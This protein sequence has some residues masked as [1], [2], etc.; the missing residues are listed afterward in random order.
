MSIAGGGRKCCTI[1]V[2]NLSCVSKSHSSQI[3]HC[4]NTHT[5]RT[6]TNILSSLSPLFTQTHHSRAFPQPSLLTILLIMR[7]IAYNRCTWFVLFCP[8]Y[9]DTRLKKRERKLVHVTMS[10]G[11]RPT[12]CL[13]LSIL[14]SVF[15]FFVKMLYSCCPCAAKP[16]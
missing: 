10:I 13:F 2:P 11:L 4:S 3:S 12:A 15:F 8:L 7:F 5:A 6:H 16:E 1:H 9:I 14:A